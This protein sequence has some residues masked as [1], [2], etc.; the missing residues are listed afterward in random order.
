MSATIK[1][2]QVGQ[3][4]TRMKGAFDDSAVYIGNPH[5]ILDAS[6]FKALEIFWKKK[7]AVEFCE[8]RGFSKSLIV[9]VESRF[10][11]GYAIGLGRG[12]FAPNH[13]QA[14]LIAHGMGCV[15]VS[16]ED[17]SMWPVN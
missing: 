12:Y 4:V 13:A 10:Q 8:N 9:R 17:D 1:C 15:V 7:D 14:R 11:R 5:K 6:T 16:I 2:V 3:N